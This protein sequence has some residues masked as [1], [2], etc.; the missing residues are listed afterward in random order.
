V[1]IKAKMQKRRAIFRLL[2][3]MFLAL[4]ALFYKAFMR[5]SAYLKYLLSIPSRALPWRASSRYLRVPN[6]FKGEQKA[7]SYKAFELIG[8][9][10][11]NLGIVELSKKY[12]IHIRK[13]K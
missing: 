13:E 8:T 3:S 1:E 10:K 6:N 12:P 7:L 2:F 9:S 5:F 4:K 11:P